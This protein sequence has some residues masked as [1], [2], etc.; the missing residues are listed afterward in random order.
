VKRAKS[1]LEFRQIRH[2]RIKRLVDS[3]ALEQNNLDEQFEQL[4][5][6]HSWCDAT[7]AA[8]N[9]ALADVESKKA[10][11]IQAE[12]DL[13]AAKA[14]VKVADATLAKARV[15][16]GYTKIRSHYNGIVT[17]RGYHN[18]DYIKSGTHGE[19]PLFT[20]QRTDKM[21][22][23]IQLPDADANYCRVGDPVQ[24]SVKT[25]P[26]LKLPAYPVERVS[27]SQDRTT[28]AMR[29]E[30]DIP[31]DKGLLCDGL[32]GNVTVQFTHFQEEQ[33]DLLKNAV[34]VPSSVLAH[35]GDKVV[36]FVV[37][38]K[39]L[40]EVPVQ[41]GSDNGNVAEVLTGLH[42]G[43]EVVTNPT[44][45]LHEGQEVRVITTQSPTAASSHH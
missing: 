39:V 8:V 15:F 44:S 19:A 2:G 37:Q 18:G 45:A 22:L 34:H 43:D 14:N 41:V 35:D 16:V 40:H 20:V 12:A 31:N 5:A 27:R 17:A 4:E 28:K 11:V 10:K 26:H 7:V 13:E 21:R 30:V 42:L 23:V 24:F 33:K 9:S 36:A 29:I 6:A 1:N 3:R 32:Y 25:L 38:N